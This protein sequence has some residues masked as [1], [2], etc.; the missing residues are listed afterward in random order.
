[1]HP[2][3]KEA[4]RAM[5]SYLAATTPTGF[6]LLQA[7]FVGFIAR[8]CSCVFSVICYT[9]SKV[10]SGITDSEKLQ[11]LMF[12]G[13]S[14]KEEVRLCLCLFCLCL[15]LFWF[16]PRSICSFHCVA[17]FVLSKAKKQRED[18]LDELRRYAGILPPTRATNDELSNEQAYVL[19][20]QIIECYVA[21]VLA[22]YV[23]YSNEYIYSGYFLRESCVLRCSSIMN[24]KCIM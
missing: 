17:I 7:L 13:A 8:L 14:D 21:L 11:I 1:M 18:V 9:E 24:N 10:S 4:L 3:Q 15:S 16:L 5:S 2:V 23:V 19:P 22:S 20:F 6:L 12:L